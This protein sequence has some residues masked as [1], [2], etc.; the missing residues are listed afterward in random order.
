[1]WP[2]VCGLSFFRCVGMIKEI[3]IIILA[4]AVMLQPRQR[5]NHRQRLLADLRRW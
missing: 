4:A 1:M 3:I 5:R 2:A